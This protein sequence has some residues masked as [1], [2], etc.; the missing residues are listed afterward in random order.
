MDCGISVTLL[1]KHN[2]VITLNFIWQTTRQMAEKKIRS[3]R[4]RNM[5]HS[6]TIAQFSKLESL[7]AT[8]SRVIILPRVRCSVTNN[9]GVS[10]G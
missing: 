2:Y 5:K 6:S 8:L 7:L 10:T 9:N 1:C 3:S 4:F